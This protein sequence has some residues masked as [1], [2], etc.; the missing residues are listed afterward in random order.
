MA[1]GKRE[2]FEELYERLEQHV[3]RLEEGGLPLDEAIALY[4][5]GMKLA[6]TCQE[7]LGEAE[8]KIS[9]LRESFAVLQERENGSRLNDGAIE[10]AY[11]A[12]DDRVSVDD[13]T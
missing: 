2:S 8:L 5:Q 9:K 10:S 12:E 1:A 4:E 6:S 3:A 13:E 7:R 11:V